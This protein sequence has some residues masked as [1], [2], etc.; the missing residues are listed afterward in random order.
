MRVLILQDHYQLATS[1]QKQLA[2]RDEAIELDIQA[3]QDFNCTAQT[4]QNTPAYDVIISAVLLTV[5][6]NNDERQHYS[7]KVKQLATLAQQHNIPFIFLSAA[8]VFDGARIAYQETDSVAPNCE[9]G[10]YY[11]AL[12]KEVSDR[13]DKPIILRTGWLYGAK[14]TNYLTAAIDY[15]LQDKCI[16]FNSAGKACPTAVEDL[17]RVLLAIVLQ[18][19]F[20]LKNWGVYH[21]VASDTALGFQFIE[22]ILIQAAKHDSRLDPKQLRFEHC[23]DVSM[24]VFYFSPVVLRCNRLLNDFGIHQR[25]WRALMPAKV[26]EHLLTDTKKAP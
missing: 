9:Y 3:W 13:C 20:D 6:T 21:Y 4:Q 15:A 18:L 12:E 22:A 1:F 16:S 26:R 25:S 14:S 11:A 8:A 2:V 24:P 17:A 5:D 7:E 23:R 10:K 19:Q